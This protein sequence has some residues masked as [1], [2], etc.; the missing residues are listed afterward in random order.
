MVGRR[1]LWVL[2]ALGIGG[3]GLV[4]ARSAA[5]LAARDA[6]GSVGNGGIHHDAV[7]ERFYRGNDAATTASTGGAVFRDVPAGYWAAGAIDDLVGAGVI[8]GFPDGTFRPEEPVT[9]AQFVSLL[10]RYLPPRLEVQT[11]VELQGPPTPV[12]S[13]IPPGYWAAADIYKAVGL[14]WIQGESFTKPAFHPLD[15]L[16][17]GQLASILSDA[18]H[19]ADD[20]SRFTFADCPPGHWDFRAMNLAWQAGFLHPIAPNRIDPDG[21]VT[22]AEAAAVLDRYNRSID[23]S[24]L[25]ATITPLGEGDIDYVNGN[26]DAVLWN[27]S[28][29][30]FAY[31]DPAKQEFE[32]G[33]VGNGT[34]Q[35]LA[36][37][38]GRYPVALNDDYVIVA[39]ADDNE[40]WI[41]SLTAGGLGKPQ[42]WTQSADT[43]REWVNTGP[44]P[45]L[46]VGGYTSGTLALELGSGRQIPLGGGNAFLS[47]DRKYGAVAA[48]PRFHRLVHPVGDVAELL[49]NQPDDP[50]QPINIWDFDAPGGPKE[51]YKVKLP[52]SVAQAAYEVG[53]ISFSPND[54]Y[55]AISVG[56]TVGD[57]G[58]LTGQI[59]IYDNSIGKLLGVAPYGNGMHWLADQSGLLLGTDLPEGQGLDKVVDLS[60]RVVDT[61]RDAY[62]RPVWA[63]NRHTFIL[64][65][66]AE[67]LGWSHLDYS[68]NED[69][70]VPPGH[71][72]VVFPS[73]NGT[74]GLLF[75]QTQPAGDSPVGVDS[76]SLVQIQST[77]TTTGDGSP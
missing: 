10:V 48:R 57:N 69:P 60:G 68:F 19:L 8:K 51:T 16:T 63:L 27:P 15:P 75:V 56:G 28:G 31:Y 76:V 4:G 65:D 45:G 12:F 6:G 25:N 66:Q 20:G 44:G 54:R 59:F 72:Y 42:A 32:L 47:T 21:T 17:R 35:P 11:P 41:Y 9:R 29:D 61:W 77:L 40:D 1:W 23:G 34:I 33:E 30:R 70:V 71:A 52:E 73:P 14:D 46:L 36:L 7:V 55:L 37:P 24:G 50:T 26:L 58:A 5:V 18:L 53:Y 3:A 64:T 22:R 43:W 62:G 49:E 38:A 39:N 2:V 74:S 13:D 67:E